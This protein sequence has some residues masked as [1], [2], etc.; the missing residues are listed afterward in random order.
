MALFTIPAVA[1]ESIGVL[2]TVLEGGGGLLGRG[3]ARSLCGRDRIPSPWPVRPR[4]PTEWL[5]DS[6]YTFHCGPDV[7]H[8]GTARDHIHVPLLGSEMGREHGG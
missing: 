1:Y 2:E 8:L 4:P 6:E 5:Q 7:G 3:G